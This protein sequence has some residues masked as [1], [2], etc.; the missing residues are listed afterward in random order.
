LNYRKWIWPV[1][2]H[3]LMA[4]I[5][6]TGA[7]FVFAALAVGAA[8]NQCGTDTD[9]LI[10]RSPTGEK[11]GMSDSVCGWAA[12]GH[13]AQ[14]YRVSADGKERDAFLH[15][16]TSVFHMPRATWTP[17]GALVIEVSH[18]HSLSTYPNAKSRVIIKF[19]QVL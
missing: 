19:G 7:L 1:I 16:N 3:A 18:A 15:Y 17:Q 8:M 12:P 5:F 11:V 4:V 9:H 13:T 2:T 10:A 6:F 14:V